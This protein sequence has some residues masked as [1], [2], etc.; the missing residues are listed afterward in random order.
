M[1]LLTVRCYVLVND[2]VKAAVSF[3]VVDGFL[4]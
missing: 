3:P 4:P 2:K 1:C